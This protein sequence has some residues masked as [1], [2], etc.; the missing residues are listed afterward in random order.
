MV[1]K[2]C[3]IITLACLGA[4]LAVAYLKVEPRIKRAEADAADKGKKLTDETEAK[5]KVQADLD[6]TKTDLA[7]TTT[8]RDNF[9]AASEKSAGEAQ[10]AK[11]QAD[12]AVNKLS[13]VTQEFEKFKSDHDEFTKLNMKAAEIVKMKADLKTTTETRDVLKTENGVLALNIKILDAKIA[14][15][16]PIGAAPALPDGLK[17]KVVAVD[18]RYQFV[19]LNIGLKQ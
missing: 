15:L 4:S 13:G 6:K 2:I 9:M 19:V 12:E 16:S 10:A 7:T 14:K 17:G 1:T 5:Q 11:S 18:P 8:D 3:W